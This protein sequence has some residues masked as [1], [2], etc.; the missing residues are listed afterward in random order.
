MDRH[1]Y[2]SDLSDAEFACLEPY[3]PA[4]KRC[5]RPWL[6]PRRAILDAIFYLV[7]TG[8]QWR[9][10]PREYPPWSTVHYWFRRWRLDGLWERVNGALRER[11]RVAVGRDPQ[12]SAAV[13][14]SQS[15]KTTGVGGVRG[16]DG[17]KKL[18]GRKRH[19]LV[20]TLGWVLKATVHRADLQDRAAV[21]LLLEEA[22]DRG[23]PGLER[24]GRAAPA[25]GARGVG[26]PRHRRRPA[27]LRVAPPAARAEGLPRGPAEAVD[28][29]TDLRVDRAE[30]P[31][32]Q[33]VR[34]A[35]GDE[36]GA[37]LRDDE[38]PDAAAAGPLMTFPH[39]F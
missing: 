4:P 24:R 25:D 3:L 5:G 21:P 36:R 9:A 13:V 14:D 8:C 6:H 26:P 39:G 30:P 35:A 32:E 23:A 12:P 22:V 28:R 11:L 31:D 37:D 38:P 27:P 34:A 18:S 7:R 15:V 2:P 33:G 17:A 29:G 19:L 20:D 1:A 10:L 16:Y